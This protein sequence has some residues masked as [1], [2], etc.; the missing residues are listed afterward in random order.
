MTDTKPALK[1]ELAEIVRQIRALRTITAQTGFLLNR[2]IGALLA[3]LSTEDLV[4]V[5]EALQVS[6]QDFQHYIR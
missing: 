2:T 6:P 3:K 1:P 4:A 5:G